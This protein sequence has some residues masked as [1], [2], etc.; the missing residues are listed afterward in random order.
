[1]APG[2]T[3]RREFAPPGN[4]AGVPVTVEVLAFSVHQGEICFRVLRQ[5][6][7]PDRHPDSVAADLVA[8]D[9]H[10]RRSGAD[11][12]PVALIHSTSWRY[13]EAGEVVLTYAALPDPAPW[14]VTTAVH[15][16]AVVGTDDPRSPA[17]SDLDMTN[18]A[19]HAV[20]HLAWLRETD[21]TVA[22]ALATLPEVWRSLGRVPPGPAGAM[23]R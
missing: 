6:L 17:P 23:A 10:G 21:E 2:S 7:A 22:A 19:A 9:R 12:A 4:G 5:P 16:M 15:G 1:M 18:V 20:R 8:G 13:S 3:S 14:A 11:R